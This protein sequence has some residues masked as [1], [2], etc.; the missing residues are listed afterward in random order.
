MIIKF[1]L[2]DVTVSFKAFGESKPSGSCFFVH[3]IMVAFILFKKEIVGLMLSNLRRL[4]G[5]VLLVVKCNVFHKQIN[6]GM[7]Y[8]RPLL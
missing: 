1:D 7:T 3:L 6:E 4:A 8:L 5:V 2:S